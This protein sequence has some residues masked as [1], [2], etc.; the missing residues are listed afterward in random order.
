VLTVFKKSQRMTVFDFDGTMVKEDSTMVLMRYVVGQN[1]MFVIPY[2]VFRAL[3]KIGLRDTGEKTFFCFF[4]LFFKKS[5]KEKIFR[6]VSDT[7]TLC[8]YNIKEGD[9]IIS[10]GYV[11]VIKCLFPSNLILA[12][13]L[14]FYAAYPFW[15][16]R[17]SGKIKLKYLLKIRTS[18]MFNRAISDNEDDE[19]FSML[20]PEVIII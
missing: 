17:I 9:I 20:I 7:L 1:I 2:F 4:V 5:T 16:T 19:I 12:R 10:G 13:E 8:G 14:S 15:S 3:R 18:S 11:D 6:S